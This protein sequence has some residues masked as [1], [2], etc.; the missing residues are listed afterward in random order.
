MLDISYL[1]DLALELEIIDTVTNNS[2]MVA[3]KDGVTHV[4]FLQIVC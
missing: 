2:R 3:V 1:N 4:D